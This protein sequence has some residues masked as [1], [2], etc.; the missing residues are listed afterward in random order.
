M[1]RALQDDS[2]M[3]EHGV[4]AAL[5]P[6]STAFCRKLCTGVIQFAY[7]CI[8]DHPVWKNQQFWEA[9]FY[10]DVQTQI[11]AL[12]LPRA[13]STSQSS[14]SSISPALIDTN[15]STYSRSRMSPSNSRDLKEYR[16]SILSRVQEP[17]ALEIAAEQM[18]LSASIDAAKLNEFISSEESTLYSQAIHYANRMVSLLIPTDVTT[19][20]RVQKHDHHL[21]DDTSVSNSVVESRSA[22]S[23]HSDEGFDEIVPGETGNIVTK[24]V[25][26][27]IDRVCTE[28]GVTAE[29]VRNLHV[30]VP[31][32]VHMH[33]ETLDAI[34]R[35]SKRIPPVQKPKIQA[36]SLL[37]GEEILGEPM[38]VYLLPDGREENAAGT[39]SLLPAEGALFLTNYRVVF[40]G[41]PC[42]PLSCEQSVVR[43]FPVSCLTKEKRITRLYLPHLDQ[44]LPDGLQLRACTFQLIK[45]AFDEE[46]TADNIESFR[47]LLNR[48]RH[49][50]NEFGHFAFASHG[51]IA[52]TPSHKVKEKNATLKGF[53]KKT[54]L[55]TA[56]RAGFKQKGVTRRKY[57][58]SG[59]DLDE[60]NATN[61][62]NFMGSVASSG[63]GSNAS[64]TDHQHHANNNDDDDSDEAV[65]TIPRVTIK[66]VERLKERSYVR[67][68]K[69][70]GF[71]D[72]HSNYRISSVNC[73]YSLSRSYPAIVVSPHGISD[74]SLRCLS[75]SYKNQRIPLAT[76]RHHRNGAILL[77]G[78]V[79][80]AKGVMG[81]LKGHQGGG[82]TNT[83][84]DS[85]GFQ[86]QDRYFIQIIETMPHSVSSMRHPWDLFDSSLSINSLL[87][88]A[89]DM[90]LQ[91]KQQQQ[92]KYAET[93]TESTPDSNRRL[94]QYG[95]ALNTV[96][97]F[98]NFGSRAGAAAAMAH[99]V[100]NKWGSLK[101]G[102]SLYTGGSNTSSVNQHRAMNEKEKQSQQQ[103]QQQQQQRQQQQQQNKK[104]KLFLSSLMDSK[105]RTITILGIVCA[106]ETVFK[107]KLKIGACVY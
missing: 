32:V 19:G 75:R 98:S 91:Q 8:Q 12:Y 11:K 48:A 49:P 63:I 33:I 95:N 82:S 37:L 90:H 39:S 85:T 10:Q 54:L 74:D 86:E 6:L 15:Y 76:W 55:R 5:L 61:D 59:I 87:L 88:A 17:S 73:N 97:S 103:M 1:N 106:I 38:R 46:V 9:A 65:D 23:D 94:S 52:H 70:L 3:D 58:L 20:G 51:I 40:R 16:A 105:C 22:R 89:E 93:K 66:D 41:S 45:I 72:P 34:N 100:T 77:R 24:M 25:S 26:R 4:A 104:T 79:P 21:E 68:W 27:F 35:E 36:P 31:G 53:A 60:V 47:K 50:P 2:I 99:K 28:G 107:Q 64:S 71:G 57:V 80:H 14:S 13:A 92:Q 96:R 29:H 81:M 69:R 18:R 44:D 84:T 101:S 83:S 43:S 30:M 102:A 56:K 67:D 62:H 7:T 78:A 42:D